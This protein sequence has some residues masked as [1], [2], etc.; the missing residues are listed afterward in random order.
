MIK[1]I[2]I[3]AGYK[4]HLLVFGAISKAI[5]DF[6]TGDITAG[7]LVN[8]IMQYLMVSTFKAGVDR[9]LAK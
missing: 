2:E 3:L 6:T 9:G 4:T 1:L 7:E 5:L 8:S